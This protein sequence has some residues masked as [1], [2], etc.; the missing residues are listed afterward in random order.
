[1]SPPYRDSAT[2]LASLQLVEGMIDRLSIEMVCE[3][4][5]HVTLQPHH[6]VPCRRTTC[7]ILIRA[8]TRLS[9]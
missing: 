4:I 7:N 6:T 9:W 1:M 2:Q 8:Y 5:P 3:V